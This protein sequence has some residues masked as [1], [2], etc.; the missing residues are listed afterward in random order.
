M[1]H[2]EFKY[3]ITLTEPEPNFYG[4]DNS[5]E[6]IA[7]TL[8]VMQLSNYDLHKVRV[9]GLDAYSWFSVYV[10]QNWNNYLEK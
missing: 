4:A 1:E 9:N 8:V 6:K 10:D 2:K 3:E 7:H 5:P